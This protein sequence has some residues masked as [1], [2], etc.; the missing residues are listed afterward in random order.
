MHRR[1]AARGRRYAAIA[2]ALAAHLVLLGVM[3]LGL[4]SR[5]LTPSAA[6]TPT[7]IALDL[8]PAAPRHAPPPA[9]A[10]APVRS[11]PPAVAAK[12]GRAGPVAPAPTPSAPAATRHIGAGPVGEPVGPAGP[13]GTQAAL[14]A[15]SGCDSADYLRLTLAEKARCDERDRRLRAANHKT[16]AAVDPDKK[17]FFDGACKKDDD[18]CRYYKGEGPYPGILALGRKKKRDGW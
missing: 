14:R 16:Y 6:P 18:W 9:P 2:A 5:D 4:L 12:A 11:P 15:S 3:G 8:T 17:D 1:I 7:F 10:P 13:V